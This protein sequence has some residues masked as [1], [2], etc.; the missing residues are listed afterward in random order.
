MGIFLPKFRHSCLI[1]FV[2]LF[3]KAAKVIG[4]ATTF[5]PLLGCAIGTGLIYAALIKGIS[6]APDQE[7]TL[8]N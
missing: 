4:L 1:N 2:L 6:Y 8:F 3:V 5:T 7:E